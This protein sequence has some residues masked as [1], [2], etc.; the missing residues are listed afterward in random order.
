MAQRATG[1]VVRALHAPDRNQPQDPI[2][3]LHPVMIDW[4]LLVKNSA[5]ISLAQPESMKLR[6]W[7]IVE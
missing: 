5:L 1:K 7:P 4:P 3:A 6:L 2:V